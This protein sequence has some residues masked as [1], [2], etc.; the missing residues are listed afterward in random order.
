MLLQWVH[1]NWKYFLKY[2]VVGATGTLIDIA[3]FAFL[4]QFTP[5]NRF[6]AATISFTAAVVNNYTWNK[7]WTFHDRDKHIGGQFLKFF[8][9][10]LGGLLLNLFFLWNFGNAIAWFLQ[11]AT[12]DLSVSANSLAKLGASGC[13]LIY[14]FL[15]NRYWTFKPVSLESN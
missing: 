15:M 5:L 9:V 12:S 3:G 6:F 7:R 8:L 4:L 1:N 14:N 11:T 13:V 10:S 2:A